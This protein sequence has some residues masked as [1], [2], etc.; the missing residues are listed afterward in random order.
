[1]SLIVAS[2]SAQ[3]KDDHGVYHTPVANAMF[4]SF[5]G[6]AIQLAMGL[7]RLGLYFVRGL[8]SYDVSYHLGR[9]KPLGF[10]VD[11]ISFPAING[12]T[13]AAAI[14]IATDQLRVREK[15]KCKFDFLLSN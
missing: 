15:R 4:L 14:T 2:N 11:F 10:I 9:P 3:V 7:L 5:M 8:K 1:M 6:G 12:F 13:S